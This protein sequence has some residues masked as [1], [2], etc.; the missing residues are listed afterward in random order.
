[1]L[2]ADRKEKTMNGIKNILWL[3]TIFTSA[4]IL[5]ASCGTLDRAYLKQVTWTNAPVVQ[6][7]TNTVVATNIVPQVIERTNIVLVTNA[8]TGAISGAA[9][10]EPVAT[11]LFPVIQTNFV[12]VF[13]T[14][15][16]QVPVT[17]LVS[18]P[19]PERTTSESSWRPGMGIRD[20]SI[21]GYYR[22]TWLI[23]ECGM[24]LSYSS[25]R[26][27]VGCLVGT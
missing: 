23:P 18:R 1:L 21:G 26:A 17:N 25:L 19:E 7:L 16:V 2:L 15:Y 8:S 14:N 5:C 13:F 24:L 22:K 27:L 12:P 6:V 11:N 9:T 20:D 4:M 3:A 10:I